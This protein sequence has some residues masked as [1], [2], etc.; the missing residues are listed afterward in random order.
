MAVRRYEEAQAR[1]ALRDRFMPEILRVQQRMIEIETEMKAAT[2][3]G[4]AISVL[5][6]EYENVQ[7]RYHQLREEQSDA[8]L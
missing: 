5:H 7:R 4:A 3:W 8:R 6:E 1:K 2:F